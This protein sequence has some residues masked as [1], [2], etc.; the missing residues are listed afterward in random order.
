MPVSTLPHAWPSPR[1]PGLAP[2]RLRMFAPAAILMFA[3]I[4]ACAAEANANAQ[5]APSTPR[6]TL[7]HAELHAAPLR[8]SFN[9][10]QLS[11]NLNT[12]QPTLV[13]RALMLQARLTA[14]SAACA[15]SDAI[16]A[17]GFEL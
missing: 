6:F 12:P 4:S 17:N 5:A 3:A 14:N 2:R 11:A 16:F 13:A 1:D 15:N 7:A 10:Y 8:D 9:R